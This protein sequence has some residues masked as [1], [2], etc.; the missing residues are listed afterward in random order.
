MMENLP[1]APEEFKRRLIKGV[2]AENEALWFF[3]GFGH[4]LQ[5][6]DGVGSLE[7]IFDRRE[8]QRGPDFTCQLCGQ[9]IEVRSSRVGLTMGHSAKRPFWKNLP[10]HTWIAHVRPE[11]I[12]VYRLQDLVKYMK[13]T[14]LRFDSERGHPYLIW[15]QLPPPLS[16][17]YCLP[18]HPHL[19]PQSTDNHFEM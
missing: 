6:R 14:E 16:N 3:E 7:L 10:K 19:V 4:K 11:G 1:V 13:F 2:S 17:L 9:T 5:G 12:N 8:P 15:C 18:D